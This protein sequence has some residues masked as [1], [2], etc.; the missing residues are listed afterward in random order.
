M[1][2]SDEPAGGPRFLVDGMAI[3][4][5]KYL[6][7]LGYDA[8]WDVRSSTRALLERAAREGRLL[9]TRNTRIG[10]E[11]E[12]R[13]PWLRLESEDPVQQLHQV[14]A[15]LDL[16]VH[17]RLFSRCILCNVALETV[18]EREGVRVRVP[19]RVFERYRVFYTCPSCGTLFWKGS[20]V[21]NTCRKMGLPPPAE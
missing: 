5:G 21:A 2:A 17:A 15:A 6:R 7:C 8:E 14:V 13:S 20:H 9:L 10:L 16:D 19:A 11:F 4:L 3:K 12:A 18:A 1:V